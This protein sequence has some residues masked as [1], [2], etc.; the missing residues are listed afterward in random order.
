MFFK[1]VDK[2]KLYRQ[3]IDPNNAGLFYGGFFWEEGQFDP[4]PFQELI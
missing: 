1:I 3:R 4:F 2:L